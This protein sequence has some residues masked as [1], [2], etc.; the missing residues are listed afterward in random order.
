MNIIVVE[1]DMPS[2]TAIKRAPEHLTCTVT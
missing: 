2:G 1:D